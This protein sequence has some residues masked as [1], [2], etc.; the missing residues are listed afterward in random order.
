M[1]H[2]SCQNYV[3]TA[4]YGIHICEKLCEN[5]C[6]FVKL[7][8]L[9][10]FS[11]AYCFPAH[12]NQGFHHVFLF[13]FPQFTLFCNVHVST[14]QE[15]FSYVISCIIDMRGENASNPWGFKGCMKSLHIFMKNLNILFGFW[16]YVV[17]YWYNHIPNF[18]RLTT[19]LMSLHLLYPGYP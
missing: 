18:M 15:N 14:A 10:C 19:S 4:F 7:T 11:K 16:Y 13:S 12:V 17:V 6:Y 9:E 2:I 1:N 8:H 3:R 5:L